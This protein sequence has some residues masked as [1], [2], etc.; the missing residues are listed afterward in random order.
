V[1]AWPADLITAAVDLL[2]EV[3]AAA[4]RAARRR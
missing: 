1:Y 4:D 3:A 2:D